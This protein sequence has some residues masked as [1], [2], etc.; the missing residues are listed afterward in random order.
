MGD[1]GK[2]CENECWNGL[3]D[4]SRHPVEQRE[5]TVQGDWRGYV[6]KYEIALTVAY[7]G[8]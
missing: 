3:C 6:I 5:S 4:P 8:L 1:H 7:S 2:V